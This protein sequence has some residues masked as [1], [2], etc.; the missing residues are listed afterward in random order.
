MNLLILTLVIVNNFGDYEGCHGKLYKVEPI[1]ELKT[2]VTVIKDIVCPNGEKFQY[3]IG[4]PS[5]YLSPLN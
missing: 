1:H 3:V 2:D 4:I 5:K